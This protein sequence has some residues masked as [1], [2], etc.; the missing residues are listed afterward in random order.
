MG[1]MGVVKAIKAKGAMD[2]GCNLSDGGNGDN[3]SN[4]FNGDDGCNICNE[5]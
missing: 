1:A 3:G 5:R 4:V 2:K